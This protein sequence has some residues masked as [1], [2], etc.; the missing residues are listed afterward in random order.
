MNTPVQPIYYGAGGFYTDWRRKIAE[1]CGITIYDPRRGPQD[2]TFRFVTAD[3]EMILACSAVI[4]LL[5]PP[6]IRC[7]GMAAEIGYAAAAHKPV[8]LITEDPVPNAFLLGCAKRVFF[9]VDAFIVWF[10]NRQAKG[11]PIL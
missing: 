11:L 4:A 6:P 3:F 2:S 8:L 7:S 1:E 10:K 9:G 5:P